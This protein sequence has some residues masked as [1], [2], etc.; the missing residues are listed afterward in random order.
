MADKIILRNSVKTA[1]VIADL[2]TRCSILER[3]FS[4]L[5]QCDI[6]DEACTAEDMTLWARQMVCGQVTG[7]KQHLR[8]EVGNVSIFDRVSRH[9]TE[10]QLADLDRMIDIYRNHYG[11][12]DSRTHVFGTDAKEIVANSRASIASILKIDPTDLLFTSGST[13]SNNMAILGLRDYAEKTGRT[14]LEVVQRTAL[15]QEATPLKKTYLLFADRNDLHLRYNAASSRG[16]ECLTGWF[17]D[18]PVHYSILINRQTCNIR[19]RN[20]R[21]YTPEVTVRKSSLYLSNNGRYKSIKA[22]TDYLDAEQR[23]QFRMVY[24][25]VGKQLDSVIASR[26]DYSI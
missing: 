21:M 13:E 25:Q 11:N 23:K 12:A 17:N 7:L 19:K 26:D 15:F 20:N 2:E 10:K 16:P 18:G 22:V 6:I 14:A 4:Y 24:P 5:A 8:D 9:A 3:A 1:H